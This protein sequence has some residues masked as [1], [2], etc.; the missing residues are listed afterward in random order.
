MKTLILVRHGKAE[1]PVSGISDYER[2]LTVRGKIISAIM[3]QKLNERELSS[4]VII[5]SPAFRAI[6]TALIFADELEVDPG[7]IILNMSI[8]NKMN[9]RNLPEIISQAGDKCDTIILFGHNPSFTEIA[10][11]LAIEGCDF[12][13]KSAAAGI[14]FRIKTWSE[15]KQ[16]SGKLEFFLKPENKL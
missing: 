3:A 4:V 1:D 11:S 9:L 16:K 12:V 2:S 14:S 7:K 5:T 15:I 13:P 6:E 8:Y 10:N